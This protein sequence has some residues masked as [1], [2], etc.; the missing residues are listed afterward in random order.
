[1]KKIIFAVAI[2]ATFSLTLDAQSV[3]DEIKQD[4]QRAA[5]NLH[6]YEAPEVV[7]DTP[8]PK[9][10]TPFYVS[11]Y[12]RHGSRYQTSTSGY[13][14]LVPLFEELEKE[15]L[16]TDTGKSLAADIKTLYDEHDR[17]EGLL[18]LR[19]GQEHQGIAQRLYDRV[20]EVFNQPDRN[21]VF[22]VSTPV[23]RVLESLANFTLSL[24]G[25]AP[26]LRMLV[27]AGD[28]FGDY[29]CFDKYNRF[30]SMR[31]FAIIDSV[32]TARLDP[33]RF[34]CSVF[35]DTA[36]A[37]AILSRPP[38]QE[39]SSS[40]RQMPAGAQNA[41]QNAQFAAMMRP[42]GMSASSFMSNVFS[43]GSIYGCLDRNNPDVFRYF[44]MDELYQLWYC[45]NMNILNS[46]GFTVENESGTTLTAQLVVKD[47]LEK[48]NSAVEGNNR[49][50]DLRF[51]HDTGIG[52]LLALLKVE[53]YDRILSLSSDN[54]EYWPGYKYLPMG[55]NLQMIFYKNK[56][57][58][59]L[60][61]LLRNENETVIPALKPFKGPYYKW[62]E[63]KAYLE[64]L[65]ADC[66]M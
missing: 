32:K 63:L 50:A 30:R 28:R 2:F 60:V 22:C 66:P 3:Y 11:H 43:A 24:K 36:K 59:V 5:G 64:G 54:L 21:T 4:P 14:R 56:K 49:A 58:E 6:Y 51:G 44:T 41:P 37:M 48:A 20:P 13:K 35:T 61:K 47:I 39:A 46:Y 42:R 62:S 57:G 40:H 10:Y 53:G 34:I 12:G 55:S 19:G 16:L 7:T 29:L 8:A 27:L 9:G 65:V 1:M 45:D 17:M 23:H 38:Q 18:T 26:Q 52:P 31:P 15:G 25:N 33:E